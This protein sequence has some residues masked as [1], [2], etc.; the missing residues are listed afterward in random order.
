MSKV[1]FSNVLKAIFKAI[2]LK[3]FCQKFSS[4]MFTIKPVFHFLTKLNLED[5]FGGGKIINVDF[6]LKKRPKASV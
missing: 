6:Y 5:F 2:F 3:Q 4:A 1:L